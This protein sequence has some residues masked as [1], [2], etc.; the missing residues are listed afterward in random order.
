MKRWIENSFGTL[1]ALKAYIDKARER[2]LRLERETGE[3]FLDATGR[4]ARLAAH[5]M[6][7]AQGMDSKELWQ[8]ASALS[9]WR[10]LQEALAEREQEEAGAPLDR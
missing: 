5:A 7:A 6:L 8:V 4:E 10:D 9:Q 2:L 1:D 3:A